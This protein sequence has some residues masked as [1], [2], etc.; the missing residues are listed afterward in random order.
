MKPESSVIF[1][2]CTDLDETVRYYR[3]VFAL[4][5]YKLLPAL[6]HAILFFFVFVVQQTTSI[7]IPE[8]NTT[9]FVLFF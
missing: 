1:F 6:L 7:T 5:V 9:S 8:T 2:P 4:P 3:D